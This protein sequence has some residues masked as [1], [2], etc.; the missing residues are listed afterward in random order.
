[1]YPF[2][3]IF[4]FWKFSLILVRK[5]VQKTVHLSLKYCFLLLIYRMWSKKI[6]F[7]L[8]K[9][10]GKFFKILSNLC[11]ANCRYR[12]LLFFKEKEKTK[13]CDTLPFSVNFLLLDSQVGRCA[14]P[15]RE[16]SSSPGRPASSAR[17]PSGHHYLSAPSGQTLRENPSDGEK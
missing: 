16:V 2:H 9:V 14:C 3:T 17:T 6:W 15:L 11:I 12:T 10:S 1:M 4:L 5:K 7:L 13:S 8:V